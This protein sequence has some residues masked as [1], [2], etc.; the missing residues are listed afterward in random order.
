MEPE[1]LGK[2][3]ELI[4]K[5]SPSSKKEEE[6]EMRLIEATLAHLDKSTIHRSKMTEL[7]ERLAKKKIVKAI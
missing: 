4:L 5:A 2:I 7:I 6:L 3:H 1:I